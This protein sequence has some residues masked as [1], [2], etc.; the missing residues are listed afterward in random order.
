MRKLKTFLSFAFISIIV[1]AVAFILIFMSGSNISAALSGFLK[2]IFGSKYTLGEVF[3]KATPLTLAGLGVA[4]G[5]KSGFNNIGAEGQLYMGAIAITVIAMLFPGIPSVL[6]IPLAI[7]SG[8]IAGGV[9]SLIPGILKAKFNISEVIVTIMFNYISIC[10]LGI[11]L[12]TVLQD[13][14][15]SFPMSPPL[16]DAATLSV[17]VKGTRLHAGAIIAV[18]SAIFIFV[19]IWKTPI[20]YEMRAVGSNP[21]GSKVA[22]ISIYKCIVLSALISGGLA[23]IAGVCEVAGLHHKLLEGISPNYGYTA[24]IVALLGKNHPMGVIASAI[25]VAALEVGSKAMQRAAGVP[26]SISS[27]IMGVIVLLILA[28][29][30]IFHRFLDDKKE[31][32]V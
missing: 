21:R 10:I 28:R 13:K 18:I 17:I 3:V 6:M 25:G 15:G 1:L 4:V 14:T 19:L 5:F 7:L 27:I 9:W 26:S 8:F 20:G 24:I 23:G 11:L 32:I 29:K 31:A 30:T 22:G 12:R 2:G 16:P